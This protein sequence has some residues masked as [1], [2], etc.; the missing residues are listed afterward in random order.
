MHGDAAP[1][2]SPPRN[3]A[4]IHPQTRVSWCKSSLCAATLF[5]CLRHAPSTPWHSTEH[6]FSSPP[7]TRRDTMSHG[8]G[9]SESTHSGKTYLSQSMVDAKARHG[10]MLPSGLV[11]YSRLALSHHGRL[12][13]V[14][15]PVALSAALS[16]TMAQAQ[17]YSERASYFPLHSA[18]LHLR[19]G[20]R[21]SESRRTFTAAI[22]R[23]FMTFPTILP[24]PTLAGT[25]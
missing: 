20:T 15:Y 13:S 23:P 8:K 17:P 22:P 25:R 1:P 21:S 16:V 6:A 4:R 11:A 7:P 12:F 19:P 2:P 3:P 14:A 24:C 9:K 5:S 10:I 18:S